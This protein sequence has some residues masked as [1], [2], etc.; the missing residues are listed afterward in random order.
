MFPRGDNGYYMRLAIH[1]NL[2]SRSTQKLTLHSARLLTC[3][4][5]KHRKAFRTALVWAIAQRVMVRNQRYNRC[6]VTH[7]SAVVTSR[8][9][10]EITHY[11]NFT[12]T[13]HLSLKYSAH[14]I[15]FS[16]FFVKNCYLGC[17]WHPCV[18]D[19]PARTVPLRG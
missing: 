5:G 3:S 16:K 11:N 19:T 1:F 8:W 4:L 9:K 18:T 14:C 7:R 10:L 2:V 15:I 13:L 17:A 12:C 6:A